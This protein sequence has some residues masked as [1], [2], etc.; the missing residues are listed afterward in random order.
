MYLDEG[1]SDMQEQEGRQ[2]TGGGQ[3]FAAAAPAY[4]QLGQL[5]QNVREQVNFGLNFNLASLFCLGQ[6]EL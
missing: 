3:A 1:G 5:A 2:A 4:Q 6:S